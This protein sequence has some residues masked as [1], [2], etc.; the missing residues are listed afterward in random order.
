VLAAAKS[1]GS[2]VGSAAVFKRTLYFNGLSVSAGV[3]GDFVVDLRH[4]AFGPALALQK[5]LLSDV[6][7]DPAVR[8]VY[9]IPN[10]KAMAVFVRTGY[11]KVGTCDRYVKILRAE[12][13][14]GANIFGSDALAKIANVGLK[15]LSME[16]LRKRRAGIFVEHPRDFDERFEPPGDVLKRKNLV[17]GERSVSFLNWRYARS[18]VRPFEIFALMG[19]GRSAIL[20]YV[21][22][23][24]KENISSVADIQYNEEGQ[25]LDD[26]L[27]EFILTM[28]DREVGSI[29]LRYVGSKTFRKKLWKYGFVPHKRASGDFMAIRNGEMKSEA[30]FLNPRNWHLFE[31]DFD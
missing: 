16:S 4:R 6:F 22:Y 19:N 31:G 3:A 5:R 15:H 14:N 9:G 10:E 27:S 11:S 28:R 26:L 25:V 18:P 20:G 24:V 21:V 8:I 13:K 29:D 23:Y 1:D 2:I 30:F 17:C 7:G 12:N